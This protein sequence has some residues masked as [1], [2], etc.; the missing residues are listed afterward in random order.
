MPKLLL[1]APCEKVLVDEAS[2]STSLIGV[3][4]EVHY[5][6]PPGTTVQKNNAMLPLTWSA[7]SIW[8]EEE[9]ADAGVE[10]IQELVIENSA[11]APLLSSQVK[12]TFTQTNHRIVAN[13][14]GMPISSRKLMLK[15]Y[16]RI[17]PTNI[18]T[19]VATFPLEVMQDVL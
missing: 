6:I 13:I 3:L 10:F 11:G 15:L 19:Q 5:K 12:W 9:P 7:V 18:P 14:V 16:Y 1:F 8:Q 17:P 2:H 4:Q